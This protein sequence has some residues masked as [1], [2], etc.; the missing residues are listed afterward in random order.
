MSSIDTYL[1]EDLFRIFL[2]GA[3]PLIAAT[4]FA[5][6]ISAIL[7]ATIGAKEKAISYSLSLLFMGAIIYSLSDNIAYEIMQFTKQCFS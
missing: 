6:F 7:Q 3:L 2:L 1:I 5:N 4:V